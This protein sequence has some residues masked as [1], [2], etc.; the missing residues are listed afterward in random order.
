MPQVN[1]AQADWGILLLTA[2]LFLYIYFLPALLAFQRGHRRFWAI[3]GLN[4]LLMPVQSTLLNYL[5]PV[6]PEGLAPAMILWITFVYCLG[7]GWVLL[8]SWALRQVAS[9]DPRLA[10]FRQ[11]KLYDAF[12]ALPLI[13]WFLTSAWQMRPGLAHD[14]GMVAAGEADLLIWLRLFSMIFSVLFCL[15]SVWLLLVRDKPLR[16]ITGFLP[17]FCAVGGTFLGVGILRLPVEELPL[18]LQALAFLLTGF[19]GAASFFVLSRLGKSFS[20][21]PAARRLVTGGPYA[22]ARHPLYAAEIV[23]LMG[24]MLQYRQ[25]WATIMGAGVIVLQVIRSLYEE[26]LLS[27]TFPE[28]EDYRRRVKRFGFI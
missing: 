4:I 8:L 25:P 14:G 16:R 23:T 27:E 17:R 21:V 6:S 12:T 3:L 13:A 20:I 28:Y 1:W 9:P 10:A 24:L 11:T 19:G 26:R 15:L 22:W 5:S 2:L 18:G 7:P